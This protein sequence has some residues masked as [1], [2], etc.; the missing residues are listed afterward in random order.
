MPQRGR[1]RSRGSSN[2]GEDGREDAASAVSVVSSVVGAASGAPDNKRARH[3][4]EASEEEEEEEEEEDEGAA[5]SSGAN[6]E[7]SPEEE[8]LASLGGGGGG[9][10]EKSDS[11]RYLQFYDS[12]TPDQQRRYE[13]FRRS[14]I[15][16]DDIREL[17]AP[18]VVDGTR[19]TKPA[20]IV[21]AGLTK[22]FVGDVVERARIIMEKR[23]EKGAICPRHLRDAFRQLKQTGQLPLMRSSGA[24][25]RR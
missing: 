3:G 11:N 4:G 24:A 7:L 1:K 13:A 25:L 18:A 5:G 17:L 12:L 23:K 2:E 8:A 22:L 15:H 16:P 14:R 21:V 6:A 10:G 20:S 9:A 19:I